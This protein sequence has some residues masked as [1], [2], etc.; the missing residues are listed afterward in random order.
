MSSRRGFLKGLFGAAALGRGLP[1][2]AQDGPAENVLETWRKLPEPKGEYKQGHAVPGTKKPAAKATPGGWTVELPGSHPVP[3]PAVDGGRVYASGGFGSKQYFC[4]EGESG[5]LVWSVDLDDDGPS[6]AAIED[7]RVVVNTESCTIFTLDALTG[8]GIWS[9]WLGDP[10]MSAPTIAAGRVFT[11][12]PQQGGTAKH[13]EASHVLG[14]FDLKTGKILWRRWIDGDAI[15]APV[16]ADGEVVVA[17]F[18]GTLFR[19]RQESGE[20]LFASRARATSAPVV[21]GGK[22]YFGRRTET[23]GKAREALS[24]LTGAKFGKDVLER[25]A[26]YL[27]VKVQTASALKSGAMKLDA[28]NG[29]AGGAPA[30]AKAEAAGRIIGQDNVATCQGYQGSRILRIGNRNVCVRGD[31]LVSVEDGAEKPAWSR[32]LKGDLARDGGFLGAPPVLAGGALFASTLAGEVIELDPATG[33]ERRSWKTGRPMRFPPVV[34]GGR[35]FL[36]TQDSRLI[37]LDT[38]DRAIGGW[39]QWGANAQRTGL[40]K[41]G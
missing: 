33:A 12:W 32:K 1:L 13:A 28:G 2:L 21:E 27:D 24:V 36:G 6:T 31:E 10:L 40:P 17:T 35:I 38:G 41:P 22:L 18:S 4:F 30:P 16:A 29:F 19:F 9:W 39:P 11:T 7:G 3:T 15:S 23:K 14:A 5:K 37:C 25:E 20:L 26:D 8:R 34:E